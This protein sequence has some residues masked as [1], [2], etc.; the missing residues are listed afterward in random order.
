MKK[1]KMMPRKIRT[2]KNNKFYN[3]KD[4]KYYNY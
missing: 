4:K 3:N 2:K 1:K